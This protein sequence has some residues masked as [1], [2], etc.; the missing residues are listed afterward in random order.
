MV[1]SEEALGLTKQKEAIS[2]KSL[3]ATT[4]F[5]EIWVTEECRVRELV[6]P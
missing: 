5:K 1:F 3:G 2:E 4:L 6:F